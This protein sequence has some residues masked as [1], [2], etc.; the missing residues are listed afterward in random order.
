MK[1]IISLTLLSF[2]LALL[3]FQTDEVQKRINTSIKSLSEK[4]LY[5]GRP[6]IKGSLGYHDSFTMRVMRENGF[7]MIKAQIIHGMKQAKLDEN[8]IASANWTSLQETYEEAV[9]RLMG[10]LSKDKSLKL[11][12]I[13]C[14]IKDDTLTEMVSKALELKYPGI[15]IKKMACNSETWTEFKNKNSPMHYR[16]KYVAYLCKIPGERAW[17]VDMATLTQTLTGIDIWSDLKV[18]KLG[19]NEFLRFVKG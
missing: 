2:V 14:E 6:G 5:E 7:E 8:S 12:E 1:K 3:S 10:Q 15:K 17:R 18:A 16:K 13:S 4:A 9:K 11:G 19:D